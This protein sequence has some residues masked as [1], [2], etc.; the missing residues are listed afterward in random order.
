MR[1]HNVWLAIDT[2]HVEQIL[3]EREWFKVPSAPAQ[4]PG[5]LAWQGRAVAVLD[6]ALVMGLAPLQ[7]GTPRRRTLITQSRDCLL[8][9]PVDEVHEAQLITEGLMRPSHATRQ[10]YASSEVSVNHT[11]MPLLDPHALVSEA[12]ASSEAASA[13]PAA[14]GPGGADP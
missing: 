1:I 14:G 6:L 12:L 11:M 2:A 8:A 13:A 5:V 9:I 7:P 3:G 4:W 10:A